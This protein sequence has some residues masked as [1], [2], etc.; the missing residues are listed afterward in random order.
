MA[1]FGTEMYSDD[2]EFITGSS[3]INHM[4]ANVIAWKGIKLINNA[5]LLLEAAASKDLF[6]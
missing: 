2:I 6:L 3:I 5:S 4:N 1:L